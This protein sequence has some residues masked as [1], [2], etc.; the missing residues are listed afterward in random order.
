MIDNRVPTI[1]VVDDEPELEPLVLQRF[2]K[3]ILGNK[4]RFEFALDGELALER[5]RLEDSVDI[6]MTDINMPKMNGLSLL[7][8]INELQLPSLRTIIVSAY[9][10][11]ANIRTAMNNGAFDFVTK[12]IN[13]HDLEATLLKTFLEVQELRE[14]EENKQRVK[15]LLEA[16][17]AQ[18]ESFS[19][20]LL[21]FQE[22][23]RKR[24]AA[25]LHDSLGQYIL[26]MKNRALMG[27]QLSKLHPDITEHFEE[28]SSI[29][30]E[31]IDAA[32]AISHNLRPYQLDRFGI[33]EAVKAMLS[34]V[35]SATE[36]IIHQEID[37]VDGLIPTSEEINLYRIVQECMN[38]IVKHAQATE[39]WFTFSHDN[40]NI[41]IEI[42]D[43]G[44][45]FTVSEA[46]GSD[47]GFGL[48]GISER[49]KILNG[50]LSIQSS[51]GKGVR[52]NI[53][54]PVSH[55]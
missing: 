36:L 2:R 5:L 25:E 19:R 38:N 9:D 33:T 39:A 1:L 13:F 14:A 50:T 18:Q 7:T 22:N 20:K 3:Q 41:H 10:D 46:S 54:I 27:L 42:R 17:Q 30:S 11:M 53:S 23:E 15:S 37:S 8:K 16:K 55:V 44:K 28:I 12:P 34:V 47:G 21:E 49:V 52:T 35:Q 24:I 48:I 45:G 6:V 32:R 43:N 26:I 51:H 40:G 29:A 31:A 4:F